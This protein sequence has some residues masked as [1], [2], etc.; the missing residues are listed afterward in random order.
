MPKSLFSKRFAQAVFSPMRALASKPLRKNRAQP[1]ITSTGKSMNALH[2]L[3][4]NRLLDA[5]RQIQQALL[6]STLFAGLPQ[7]QSDA[8]SPA[9]P[10]VAAPL[11]KPFKPGSFAK[12]AFVFA[13]Q[14]HVYWLYVPTAPELPKSSSVPLV[15]MLHG[16][17]Q[18]ALA[19][20]KGTEMNAAAEQHGV[21]V[22]YPEQQKK[23]NNSNCWN[24][25]EPGHQ[26]RGR[27]EPALLAALV[28]HVEEAARL[29]A[30]SGGT[31]QVDRTRVYAAGL[32]AGGAMAAVLG[33][34]YA[35]VFAAVGVHSGLA[36]G[37][38]HDVMS[39]FQAMRRAVPASNSSAGQ[40][41]P[42]IV[43]QGELDTTVHPSNAARLVDKALAAFEHSGQPLMK[44][45]LQAESPGGPSKTCRSSYKNA[46]GKTQVELQ[47]VPG[48]AHAWSGGSPNGSFTAPSGPN[49]SQAMLRFF[50]KHRLAG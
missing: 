15:M 47:T 21:M 22:L 2:R 39:A 49:A 46:S 27:G 41:M 26:Q 8:P 43:F 28:A 19:F 29:A 50:L 40:A 34:Q 32:S 37:S 42:T 13:G 9:Q 6:D 10:P 20:S 23:A 31:L 24:W 11:V 17:K 33:Q 45:D 18:D 35:D 48:L 36:T 14:R 25:F 5:T 38:A 30:G 3:S 16:C 1:L 4:V 7:T 12:A 44:A